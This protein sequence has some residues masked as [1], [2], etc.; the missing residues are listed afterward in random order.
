MTTSLFRKKEFWIVGLFV[1]F[2][3]N[4]L[5]TDT[6]RF[7]FNPYD[8]RVG[9]DLS[10]QGERRVDWFGNP[11]VEKILVFAEVLRAT[12]SMP[13]KERQL[14]SSSS[15][16][17]EF[18]GATNHICGFMELLDESGKK[19]K[20]LRPDLT[21]SNCFPEKYNLRQV[22]LDFN[23]LSGQSFLASRKYRISPGDFSSNFLMEP[24]KFYSFGHFE[25]TDVFNVREP[26]RYQ[27][28]VWPVIY[29]RS[30]TN[31][32]IFEKLILLPVTLPIDVRK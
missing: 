17:G 24:N 23:K 25:L 31:V 9:L 19:V 10:P 26:G 20:S 12:N 1:C 22:L 28:K 14:D 11:L 13:Q 4:A 18:F 16:I 5:A 29:K 3:A 8:F 21:S 2:L 6:N 7:Q 15:G 32:D 30:E 27:L